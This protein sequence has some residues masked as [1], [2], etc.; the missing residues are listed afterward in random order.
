M[1]TKGYCAHELQIPCTWS[2]LSN[3][4]LSWCTESPMASSFLLHHPA[5]ESS[6][7]MAIKAPTLQACLFVATPTSQ[8][9]QVRRYSQHHIIS[10]HYWSC[11]RPDKTLEHWAHEISMEQYLW[12]GAAAAAAADD[13]DEDLFEHPWSILHVFA[14]FFLVA[15]WAFFHVQ[16]SNRGGG[17]WLWTA[18]KIECRKIVWSLGSYEFLPHPITLFIIISRKFAVCTSSCRDP[19]LQQFIYYILWIL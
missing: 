18:K 6:Y 7:S 10:I 4:I 5:T 9:I 12:S 15:K 14:V 3:I 17:T 11:C 1:R 19:S 8:L 16:L 13:D 2:P